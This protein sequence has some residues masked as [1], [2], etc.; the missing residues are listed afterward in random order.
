MTPRNLI[1]ICRVFAAYEADPDP[2]R[3]DARAAG[4]TGG[5]GDA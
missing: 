2:D 4:G 3:L 5:P 1:P